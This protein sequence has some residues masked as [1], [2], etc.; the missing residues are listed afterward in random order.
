MKRK[1]KELIF[2]S[3]INEDGSG[4]EPVDEEFLRFLND[5]KW[6]RN[7]KLHS[8]SISNGTYIAIGMNSFVCKIRE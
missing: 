7:F 8:L 4:I 3:R 2:I 1:G 5:E 6:H